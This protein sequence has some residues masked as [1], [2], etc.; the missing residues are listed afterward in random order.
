VTESLTTDLSRING[1]F[2]IACNTAFTFKGKRVEVKKI[3]RELNVRY[4]LEGSVQRG[5]SRL[6]VNVQLID[7]ETGSHIW[8]ERFEKS[9]ADLFE[10]QDEIVS[11]LAN[12]LQAQ[13]IAVEARRAERSAHPDAMDLYFQGWTCLYKG[14][15]PELNAQARDFFA[16]AL[17]LDACSVEALV[18]SALADLQSVVS[19]FTDDGTARMKT[20]ETAAIKALSLAPNNARAHSVLGGIYAFTNRVE[21]GIAECERTVALDQNSATARSQIGMAKYF[22]GRGE[23]TEAHVREALRLSPR[24]TRAYIWISFV[25][26][27]KLW[28]GADAEAVAWLRRS[29]DSNRTYPLVHFY[30]AAALAHLGEL[31]EASAAARAGL[32]LQPSFTIS[33]YRASAACTHPAYLAG[34][35]RTYE[36]LRLAGVPEG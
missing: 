15:N 34:R 25:G 11:L 7:A 20:A 26:I 19:S 1:A 10:M 9:I 14:I 16:R 23:E 13:L 6:R 33:R 29:I 22:I 31:G 21:L 28:L 17:R 12:T 2:V 5:G 32:E 24:D 30:L 3:G 27:A 35:E 8:A 36:G 4:V 18:G